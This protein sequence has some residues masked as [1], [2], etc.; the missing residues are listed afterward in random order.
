MAPAAAGTVSSSA[1][2]S[3]ALD[4]KAL[5]RVL[6][7][8][9]NWLGDVCL[10]APAV[11]ALAAAAPHAEFVAACRPSLA[12]LAARLPGV[13][14]VIPLESTRGVRAPFRTARAYREARCDTAIVMARSLRAALP[15]ALARVPQR[16][17]FGGPGASVLFTHPVHGWKGL[18]LPRRRAYFGALLRPFGLPEPTRPL[19][20]DPPAEALA[21]ADA[22]LEGEPARRDSLPVV[23]MEP[24]GAYGV[25]KRWPLDRYAALAARL[26]K[27][28]RAD[29][30]VVG[31]PEAR[32]LEARLEA[33]AGVPILKAAGKTD[34]VQLA[35]LLA[36]SALLVTNDTGP[37][38]VAA[39]VGTPIL[40]LFGSTDPAGCGPMGRGKT[41]VLY[42]KVPC[43]PCYL[44]ECPVEGHP[45]LDQFSVDRVH[46]EAVALLRVTDPAGS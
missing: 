13:T 30:L 45:C 16:I 20:F 44:R 40:A 29:V 25:A 14:S 38:H 12:S 37:M 46:K 42:E 27:D 24:G 23:A 6:L 2:A 34:L 18:R 19:A 35:A 4:P 22:F 43:S 10:A 39:A 17:G 8:L 36:R 1:G 41:T 3:P 9:P 7:R 5:R 31:A 15:V 21:W 26:V 11:E 28:G 33:A 32:D